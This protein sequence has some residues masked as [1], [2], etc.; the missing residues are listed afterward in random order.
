MKFKLPSA[1]NETQ[2]HFEALC[3]LGGGRDGGPARSKV[4]DLLH[5]SGSRLNELAYDE[6]TRA[7]H[8]F[9]D[10]D[11][12]K[13]CFSVAL[14]WGH[15]AKFDMDFLDA[16]TRLLEHWNDDD[17]KVATKF[18]F[19]RGPLPIAHSL[20]GGNVLFAKVRLPAGLPDSLSSY[21][22]AQERWLSPI[23]SPERPRYIG[24]WNATGMFMVGLFSNPSLSS[25]LFEPFIMLPPG[26]PIFNGLKILHQTHL[27][28]R[29]P[30]GSELDDADFEPGAIYENNGL[31]VDILKGHS[32]WS[33]LDVHSGLYMLG[34]RL[35]GADK[36]FE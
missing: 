25:E 19:E 30:A 8:E 33:L 5:H 17:L 27:L 23:V 36:W 26:G 10:R 13:V 32:G 22:R 2:R 9:P 35:P 24:S 6:I 1:L 11:P 14:C 3:A 31:F 4:Q 21:R 16:A 18:H 12:W 28:S 20:Q 34:T 29:P 15:I 7:L